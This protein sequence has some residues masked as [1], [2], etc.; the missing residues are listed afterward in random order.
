MRQDGALVLRRRPQPTVPFEL[1]LAP[2]QPARVNGVLITVERA[3][4]GAEGQRIQLPTS[5]DPTFV[6]RSRRPGDRFHPL[7]YPA[8][9][10]LKSFLISRKVPREQRDRLALVTWNGEIVWVA[11]VAVSEG[12]KTTGGEGDVYVLSVT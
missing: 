11:G 4:S 3:L 6:V 12:F 2:D 9:T 1:P 10:K 7:G 5:A 8:E